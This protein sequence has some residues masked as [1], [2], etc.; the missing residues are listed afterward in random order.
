M[1]GGSSFGNYFAL[2]CSAVLSCAGDVP[3]SL[4]YLPRYPSMIKILYL[5]IMGKEGRRNGL[6]TYWK[7]QGDEDSFI[8]IQS[9]Q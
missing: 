7:E 4:L 8:S 9:Q 5:P 6:P 1:S 3:S 2:L